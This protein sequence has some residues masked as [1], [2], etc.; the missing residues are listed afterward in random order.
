M[1]RA[2]VLTRKKSGSRRMYIAIAVVAFV[3]FALWMWGY[4]APSAPIGKCDA[5]MDPVIREE[6]KTCSAKTS[7][8]WDHAKRACL[9]CTQKYSTMDPVT[10]KCVV[11]ARCKDL[12]DVLAQDSCANCEEAKWNPITS[13]CCLATEKYDGVSKACVLTQNSRGRR[14]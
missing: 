14:R 5:I 11:P 6:C 10:M 1:Y 12:T 8:A 9:A 4:F 13:M 2:K 7:S 3:L